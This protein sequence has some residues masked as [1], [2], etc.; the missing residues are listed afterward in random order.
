MSQNKLCKKCNLL[1]SV[2]DFNKNVSRADGLSV[3][4]K[5]CNKTALKKHYLA[6]KDY[7][8]S[9]NSKSKGGSRV[10]ELRE[11]LS[12]Y[13]RS[14]PCTD[15]GKYFHPVCMDF[16]HLDAKSKITEISR[17]RAGNYSLA[18]IKAEMAKCELVCA[19]CH[20]LRGLART[21]V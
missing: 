6:N 2:V 5:E 12:A 11:F 15:C 20:R 16:D 7:Y 18:T 19:C 8:R 10:A 21:T 9:R 17:L 4:C 1:K 14:N 13:K 3:S